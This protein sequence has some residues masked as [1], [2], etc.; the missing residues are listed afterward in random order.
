[1]S[2]R[3][4]LWSRGC[5][6]H[7]HGSGSKPSALNCFITARLEASAR[8]VL[9]ERVLGRQRLCSLVDLVI[10]YQPKHVLWTIFNDLLDS[11]ASILTI[12]DDAHLQ[13]LHDGNG[14]THG[15]RDTAHAEQMVWM[16][17]VMN[18]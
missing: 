5:L 4:A 18:P 1:M 14:A 10:A 17:K 8:Q 15:H 6:T 2:A 9:S 3:S 7:M 16:W 12:V 13:V 11:M